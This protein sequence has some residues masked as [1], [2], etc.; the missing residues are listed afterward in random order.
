MSSAWHRATSR[1]RLSTTSSFNTIPSLKHTTSTLKLDGLPPPSPKMDL[2]SK[3]DIISNLP[4]FDVD[5]VVLYLSKLDEA[6]YKKEKL[7]LDSIKGG[8]KGEYAK[9]KDMVRQ[10]FVENISHIMDVLDNQ[11]SKAPS[12]SWASLFY[13][14][15]QKCQDVMALSR[16]QHYLLIL[17][18][19]LRILRKREA[20]EGQNATISARIKVL[21][22]LV[23]PPLILSS[24]LSPLL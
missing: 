14:R 8:I 1:P 9:E 18:N 3:L 10:V 2:P 6:K 19:Y 15:S 5:T 17:K 12:S 4:I 22:L 21:S 16:I 13:R 23:L 20:K 24:L 11:R 7:S